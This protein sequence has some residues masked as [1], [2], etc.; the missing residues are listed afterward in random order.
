V[1]NEPILLRNASLFV[2]ESVGPGSVLV[3]GGKVAAVYKIGEAT[4]D[5]EALDLGGA[6]LGPG[7]I[8]VHTHGADGVELMNGGDTALRMAR[9]FA[10]HGV[11]GFFPATVTDSFE[12]VEGAMD[13][14]RKAMAYPTGSA[15]VLGVHLEGPFI[16]PERLGA[17][18]PDYCIP[19]TAESVA[20]LIAL[21]AGLPCIVT[22]APEVEGGMEAI[23]AFVEAG[24]IVSIGHTVASTEEA[25][26]AFRA[27]ATQVTHMFNGMPPMHHR[28]PG[29]VG[30]ALT[31]R[32]VRIELIADGV[33]LHPTTV[34]MA[35]A[36]KGVDDVLLVTDSISATGCEDGEYVL[37]PMKVIVVNGEARI[38]ESGALAGSTLTLERGVVNVARWTDAGLS[39]AWQMASL[40]PARQLGL[41]DHLGRVAPGYDADLA[42]VDAGG[43]VVLTMVG[44]AVVYRA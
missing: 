40:N 25:E 16:S 36:A 14:V 10:R 39:G 34:H 27:G 38:V 13:S 31:T 28:T 7:L 30:T 4:P 41:D 17:Q 42:A 35:I 19:P 11:T 26:A 24:M 2:P 6:A 15:R 33:H 29:I 12:A 37:G 3:E 21:T 1:A 9:F 20:R 18:S 43:R 22:V 44:G 5:L 8:D 32:G 23:H